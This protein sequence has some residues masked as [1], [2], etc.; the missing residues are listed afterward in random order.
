[1][2][3]SRSILGMLVVLILIGGAGYG[4]WWRLNPADEEGEAPLAPEQHTWR[5]LIIAAS[6]AISL[7]A[8][9]V[10]RWRWGVRRR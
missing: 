4:I 10:G 5:G 1:M 7:V 9:V 8:L 6:A 3:R 2:A